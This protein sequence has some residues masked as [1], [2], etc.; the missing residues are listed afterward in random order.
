MWWMCQGHLVV[1]Q[2]GAGVEL[3][4]AAELPLPEGGVAE[5]LGLLA[6]APPLLLL[7]GPGVDHGAAVHRPAATRQLPPRILPGLRRH[8]LLYVS[9]DLLRLKMFH[10]A[11]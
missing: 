2:E 5:Q 3:L 4:G 9:R 7:A 1:L 10:Y 8:K 11:K 6:G